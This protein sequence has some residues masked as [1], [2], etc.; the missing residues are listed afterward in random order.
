MVSFTTILPFVQSNG[1]DER[2]TQTLLSM[3]VKAAKD[4]I[5][6][7]DESIDATDISCHEST[8][9]TPFEV[10]FGRKA[11]LPIESSCA[12]HPPQSMF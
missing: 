1:L 9:H 3:L 11:L 4:H 10:M 7:W 8:L 6:I 12:V 2:F 5:H